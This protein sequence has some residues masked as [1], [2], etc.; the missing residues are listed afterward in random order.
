M[1]HA[2]PKNLLMYSLQ[3]TSSRN[4]CTGAVV[5]ILSMCVCIFV[6]AC[7]LIAS[8][9]KVLQLQPQHVEL[10]TTQASLLHVQSACFQVAA[11]SYHLCII[12]PHAYIA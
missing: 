5:T 7:S 8:K 6:T 4:H 10:M 2:G 12:L 1:N 3:R 9:Y 11:G